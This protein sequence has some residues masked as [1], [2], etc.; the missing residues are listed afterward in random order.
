MADVY[1]VYL[2]PFR[3]FCVTIQR[4]P[5][6]T[7]RTDENVIKNPYVKNNDEKSA[8]P[9]RPAWMPPHQF[10]EETATHGT[11]APAETPLTRRRIAS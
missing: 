5:T 8:D 2:I 1:S 3:V 7:E 10:P 4:T 6:E 11:A 9:P